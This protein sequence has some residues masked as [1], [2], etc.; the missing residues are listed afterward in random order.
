MMNEPHSNTGSPDTYGVVTE[1]EATYRRDYS[2][3]NGFN[4]T[5]SAANA[6]STV[7]SQYNVYA[8]FNNVATHT[9]PRPMIVITN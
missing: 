2:K 3:N 7:Q 8:Y 6:D 1:Q 4:T 9:L 5:L